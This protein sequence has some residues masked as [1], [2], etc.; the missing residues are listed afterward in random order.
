MTNC[1][2][3]FCSEMVLD[4]SESKKKHPMCY[5]HSKMRDGL[6]AIPSAYGYFKSYDDGGD[7]WDLERW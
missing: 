3:Y 1:S 4:K 5:C 6:Y 2:V 7:E